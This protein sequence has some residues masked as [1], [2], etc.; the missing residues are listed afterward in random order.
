MGPTQPPIQRVP[1]SDS[2]W[3]GRSGDRNP[4]RER[5][6]TPVQIGPVATQPPLQLVP[7]FFPRVKRLER[8]VN[9]HSYLA[10][11]LKKE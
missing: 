3:T 9:N 6:S 8:G 1:G 4:T 2:L 10:P 5:F 7:G 11:R